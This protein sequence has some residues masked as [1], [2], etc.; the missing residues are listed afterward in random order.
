V[1]VMTVT[2]DHL[3]LPDWVSGGLVGLC[4]YT[5]VT[6]ITYFG[7]GGSFHYQTGTV[8]RMA[9]GTCHVVAFVGTGSPVH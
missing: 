5:L 8:D 9:V 2:A 1:G 6:A 7:L 3:A 4:A